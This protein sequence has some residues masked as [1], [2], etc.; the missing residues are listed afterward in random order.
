[1]S[2]PW[3]L[4]LVYLTLSSYSFAQ[5]AEDYLRMGL[6]KF[7]SKEYDS[8]AIYCSKAIELNP[9]YADAFLGR[10]SAKSKLK[11]NNAAMKDLEIVIQLDSNDATAYYDVA[12][13]YSINRDAKN[14]FS[15][16]GKAL[17]KGFDGIYYLNT[18]PDLIF[19]RSHK[20]FNLLLKK[21]M[22]NN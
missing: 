5:T 9:K 19:L 22:L 13:I 11:D 16:L 7:R 2:K 10:A 6:L 18:D 12:C 8:S 20:E 4:L 3:P 21:Y 14:G 15:F 1:M 17:A